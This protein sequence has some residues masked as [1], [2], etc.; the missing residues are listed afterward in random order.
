MPT[1]LKH[2]VTCRCV[3]PQFKR[4]DKPPLHQFVVFSVIDDQNNVVPKYAQCNNCGIVHR[5]T[6]ICRSSIVDGKEDMRSIKTV[7]DVMAGLPKQLS[8]VLESAEADIATWEAAQFIYENKQWGNFVV[9]TTD[10]DSGVKQGKYVQIL[11]ESMF[12]VEAFDR[13]EVVA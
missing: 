10:E 6:D 7:V 11:S 13:E 8:N 5:V 4:A 12:K 3:L 2:L 9:L 1:G